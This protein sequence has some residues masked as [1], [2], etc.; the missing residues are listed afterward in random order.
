MT[1]KKTR[2]L[3]PEFLAEVAKQH[4]T[5]RAF[6]DADPSAFVS[7]NRR[8]PVILDKKTREIVEDPTKAPKGSTVKVSFL[9]HICAHMFRNNFRWTVD[10]LQGVANQYETRSA[11]AKGDKAAYSAAVRQ[12][13]LDQ[14]CAHMKKDQRG[15]MWTLPKLKK[16]AKGLS[17]EEFQAQHKNAYISAKRRDLLD[18]LF[19]EKEITT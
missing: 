10:M 2:K 19:P 13:V 9:D 11:F 16:L 17:L 1:K 12:D 7:A 3:T 18:Q 5:K 8:D 4:K 14:I 6:Y 15:T